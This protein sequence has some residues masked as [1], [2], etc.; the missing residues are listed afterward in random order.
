[1]DFAHNILKSLSSVGRRALIFLAA[2]TQFVEI[3]LEGH[4]PKVSTFFF[5][6]R[7][8]GLNKKDRGVRPIAIGFT[9]RRLVF[10]STSRFAVAQFAPLL[11]LR[12]LGV[13]T[14]GGYEAAI[15][16]ARRFLHSMLED[17]IL[18]KLDFSN[19][20]NCLHRKNMLLLVQQYIPD[21][22][23]NCFLAYAQPARLYF[24]QHILSSEKGSQQGDILS[25]FSSASPF[26]SWITA[27][28]S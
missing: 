25:P 12:H 3:V 5:G 22:Y 23:P 6:V 9:L 16:S 10:K 8:I 15:Q 17:Q 11:C 19:A 4:C 20:S 7:L 24:G 2:L 27:Y 21:M 18:V 13:G 14:N 28:R 26:Y 1:M